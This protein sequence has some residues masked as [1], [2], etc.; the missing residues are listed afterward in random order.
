MLNGKE[1]NSLS[2]LDLD[3]KLLFCRAEEA[4]ET[5]T[6]PARRRVSTPAAQK[7]VLKV[8]NNRNS[9]VS[10]IQDIQ[11]KD[12]V[13]N[14]LTG[15]RNTLDDDDDDDNEYNVIALPTE[16]VTENVPYPENILT[17][18]TSITTQTPIT[19][20]PSVQ[21]TEI[22]TQT[23]S[24]NDD[25]SNLIDPETTTFVNDLHIVESLSKQNDLASNSVAPRPFSRPSL[26][27]T[28][29]PAIGSRNENVVHTRETSTARSRPTRTRPTTESSSTVEYDVESTSRPQYSYRPGYRGSAKFRTSTVRT[30]Q[31][32]RDEDNL[33]LSNYQPLENNRL[34]ALNENKRPPP[35]A[36]QSTLS[37]TTRRR[38]STTRTRPSSST[39]TTTAASVE[40]DTTEQKVIEAKSFFK[41]EAGERPERIRFELGVGR[42]IDFGFTPAKPRDKST[43]SAKGKVITGP[44]DNSPLVSEREYKKGHV[45]EIP[46]AKPDSVTVKSFS[47]KLNL[48]EIPLNKSDIE[49]FVRDEDLRTD[50]PTD[51]TTRKLRLKPSKTGFLARTQSEES[52]KESDDS[53][54]F[55]TPEESSTTRLRL[56]PSKIG[57]LQ[58]TSSVEDSTTTAAPEESSSTR[59]RLRPSKI[60]ILQR[61][62][63][64]E[65]STTAAPEESSSTRTRLRPSKIGFLQRTQTEAASTEAP[66][67]DDTTSRFRTRFPARGKVELEREE[68]VKVDD[69]ST[70]R[71][72]R[73]FTNRLAQRPKSSDNNIDDDVVESSTAGRVRP[74]PFQ[75]R[76]SQRSR[77]NG[78]RVQ[79]EDSNVEESTTSRTLVRPSKTRFIQRPRIDDV[80]VED[81]NDL[82]TE[83]PL[84]ETTVRFVRLVPNQSTQF[85][86]VPNSIEATINDLESLNSVT[87]KSSVEIDE[88]EIDFTTASG[89]ESSSEDHDDDDADD[90]D[91]TTLEPFIETTSSTTRRSVVIKKRPVK[92][93][94]VLATRQTITEA[95]QEGS[96]VDDEDDIET[97]ESPKVSTESVTRTRP[98]RKQVT[99]KRFES[100]ETSE[101]EPSEVTPPRTTRKRIV[102]TRTRPR[103]VAEDAES[104]DPSEKSSIDENASDDTSAKTIERKRV[105]VYKLRTSSERP[106]ESDESTSVR[107]HLSRTRVFKRPLPTQETSSEGSIDV[108][109][110]SQSDEESSSSPRSNSR[111]NQR[112]VVKIKKK[113]LD[114][115]E[116]EAPAK[117]E[118]E[119][120]TTGLPPRKPAYKVLRTKTPKLLIERPLIDE[121]PIIQIIQSDDDVQGLD[122]KNDYPEDDQSYDN[123]DSVP[124]EPARPLKY[125]T[126][127][128][129]NRVT[130]KRRPVFNAR[131]S[132]A[133]N[134]TSVKLSKETAPTR[135]RKVTIT[136]KFKPS[137]T[138]GASSA[139]P[140][141]EIDDVKKLALNERN[142]KIF[143]KGYRKSLSTTLAPNITPHDTETTEYDDVIDTTDIPT[144]TNADDSIPQ[145]E[146][147]TTKPRFS[148]SRFTTTTIRPTTLHHV[149]AIDV[150]AEENPSQNKSTIKENNA[151]EVIKKLQKLIEINRIVEVY[152]KEEKHKVLKNKKLKSI[153]KSE[154]TVEKPPTLDKFGVISRETIIKLVKRNTTSTER[155]RDGKSLFAETV[156][157]HV[158]SST[159][160][161]EGLFD[162]EKKSHE[163]DAANVTS[164]S[165]LRA[166]VP[167]L[168]PESN[169]TDPIIISL[170]SLD[171]VILSKVGRQE[172]ERDETTEVP[173]DTTLVDGN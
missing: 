92:K 124:E 122:H 43:E 17:T 75:N 168:R 120:S 147:S 136:R 138:T 126:R 7:T 98:T 164:S 171:K 167:L 30:G 54:T 93:I 142:K 50:S 172:K 25:G 130:I 99:R 170:K 15:N 82:Q 32:D 49:S 40:E 112:R 24:G 148:L 90:E 103:V 165:H 128:V 108:E 160:S 27:R 58:R 84:D 131:P 33:A 73:P 146:T 21:V 169:E 69:T 107:N 143:S 52:I 26:T 81:V 105:K 80:K 149:F 155:P 152:S 100:P 113:L 127:P 85:I 154:L 12:T 150:E 173:E 3:S 37:P 44:L 13:R 162:R 119:S 121:S 6:A 137:S 95:T 88:N 125:P 46:L 60:G 159:I 118:S 145:K 22:F 79:E 16:S 56:R 123:I 117:T 64:E 110:S 109:S 61:A 14:T 151:D 2:A 51:E 48:N 133:A 86:D 10:N 42:K 157:G 70:T 28:R 36:P 116:S 106:A 102:V 45:E 89:V 141:E 34:R 115:L 163:T 39:K 55:A 63:S 158:E 20:P 132:T 166:P 68:G 53:T 11:S 91:D 66:A 9:I 71:R 67:F 19:S 134:P 8:N 18:R 65:D 135:S 114:G 144:D 87:E 139:F 153:N 96:G 5:T 62:K 94:D 78:N 77:L 156:F 101:D 76:F 47:D 59:S 83:S 1:L 29:A 129:G 4:V 57:V 23:E 140:V 35:T 97:S 74:S 111:F 38:P 104:Q 31:Y 41:L 161:L 72:A